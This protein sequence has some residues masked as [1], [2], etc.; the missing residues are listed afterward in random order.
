[1]SRLAVGDPAPGFTLAGDDATTV[2]LSQLAGQR[3]VLYFYPADDTPGCTKEAC[4]FD[5]NLAAFR[6]AKVH[7]IGVSPDDASSHQAFRKKFGLRLT[8]LSDPEK[9]VMAR[10]GAHGE[11]M[12]YGKKVVGTIRSTF[13]VGPTGVIEHAW[14]GPRT[15]GHAARVLAALTT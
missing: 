6:A 9:A 11:K 15:E 5:A 7:V 3:F 14:Y 2:S 8:L 1:M 4:Q 12:L 13:V 10:Y